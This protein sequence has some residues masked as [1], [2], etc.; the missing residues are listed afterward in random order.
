MNIE[1]SLN[2]ETTPEIELADFERIK[3]LK[4]EQFKQLERRAHERANVT[5]AFGPL[6]RRI[7]RLAARAE[8]IESRNPGD[9]PAEVLNVLR[10]IV[11]AL[12]EKPDDD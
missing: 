2:E 8:N 5:A 4:L 3:A 6:V 12:N 9:V 1:E 7:R 10:R 11:S